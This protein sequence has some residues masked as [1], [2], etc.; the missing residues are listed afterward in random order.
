[1]PD[2]FDWKSFI[3][4]VTAVVTTL[5]PLLLPRLLHDNLRRLQSESETRIKRL[6]ALE[7]AFSVATTAKSTLGI[8][9]P[10]HDLK[11]E[12]QQIVHE[13]ASPVVLSREA[14]E[15]WAARSLIFRLTDPPNFTVPVEKAKMIRNSKYS[16]YF[17]NIL[18]VSFS[19]MYVWNILSP[20]KLSVILEPLGIRSYLL[21]PMVLYAISLYCVVIFQRFRITRQALR[22][23]RAMPESKT[24][25]KTGPLLAEP[26]PQPFA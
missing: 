17:C 7:K 19:I 21:M 20:E 23:V 15:E 13:F 10:T 24:A 22:I 25:E 4:L 26:P 1:M 14:L 9:I 5:L 3:G 16:L 2:A 12:L 8:E 18:L 11:N 6:E